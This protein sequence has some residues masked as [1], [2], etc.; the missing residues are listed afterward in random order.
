MFRVSLGLMRSVGDCRPA[1][2]TKQN[3]VRF[4]LSVVVK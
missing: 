4:A 1:G 3:K 2:V